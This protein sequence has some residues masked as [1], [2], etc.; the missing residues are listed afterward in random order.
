MT[1]FSSDRQT[2]ERVGHD[3]DRA[4]YETPAQRASEP[5]VPHERDDCGWKRCLLAPARPG[6]HQ[7]VRMPYLLFTLARLIASVNEAAT[8]R[9]QDVGS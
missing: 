4:A 6:R 1:L 2:P 9:Y 3:R 5:P 8:I 7:W